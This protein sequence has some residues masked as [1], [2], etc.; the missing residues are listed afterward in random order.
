MPIPKESTNKAF[1]SIFD[2]KL[3]PKH[4]PADVIQTLSSTVN[5]LE[6]KV[7]DTPGVEPQHST[8]EE[9]D[10]RQAMMQASSSNADHET[11]HLDKPGKTLHINLQELAK[12][13]LPYT[14]PPPPVPLASQADSSDGSAQ[15]DQA[16]SQVN[17]QSTP[18]HKS[19]TTTL[20]IYE[21]TWPNGQKTYRTHTTPI[22]EEPASSQASRNSMIYVPPQ[23]HS[24]PFL[25]R[26]RNRHLQYLH[27]SSDRD[28]W[29]A[30]SVKRQRK[31]KM[32][33]HKY[34]KLM[35]RTKTLRRKLDRL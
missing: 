19:Y 35:K 26:M 23:S 6:N 1:S 24:Q 32:K 13:F 27:R 30:I 3:L 31:L 18:I 34:K 33:K 28:T 8:S 9:S 29:M 14:P 12:S 10:F 16:Q 20:T 15:N 11:Q 7:L 25:A 22:V 17:N 21:S 5:T 4:Q 2:V